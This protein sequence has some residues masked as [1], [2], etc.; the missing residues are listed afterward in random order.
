MN[1]T[2][3]ATVIGAVCEIAPVLDCSDSPVVCAGVI[4]AVIVTPA[5]QVTEG[6]MLVFAKTR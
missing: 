4:A 5:S 6:T 2:R 1:A 3:F